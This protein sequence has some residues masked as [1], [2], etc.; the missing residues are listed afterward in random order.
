MMDDIVEI[1]Y[2]TELS[3]NNYHESYIKNFDNF[4]KNECERLGIDILKH[5]GDIYIINGFK[6]SIVKLFF[7]AAKDIKDKK[8]LQK[9]WDTIEENSK[10][11]KNYYLKIL[12]T[13]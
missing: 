3:K 8:E 6:Y 9:F 7:D 4:F 1:K 13:Y 12:K 2:D 11:L 5:T 10:K